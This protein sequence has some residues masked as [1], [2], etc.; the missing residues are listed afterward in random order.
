MRTKWHVLTL[1]TA[2]GIRLRLRCVY[3]L[4]HRS[5]DRRVEG[6]PEPLEAM[7]SSGMLKEK[8]NMRI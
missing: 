3:S 6:T 4:E 7:G 5:R 1:P 8:V 2:V